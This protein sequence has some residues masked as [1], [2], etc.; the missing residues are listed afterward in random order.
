MGIERLEEA[1]I[2]VASRE[3]AE[4]PGA[5]PEP[6][7]QQAYR[8]RY[9]ATVDAV[10]RAARDEAWDAA[11]LELRQAW[12]AHETKWPRAEDSEQPRRP[13]TPGTWRGDGDRS[14]APEANAEVERGCGRIATLARTSS[15]PPC[16]PSKPKTWI[17]T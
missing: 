6:Q 8:A 12:Q 10:N 15:R 7:D 9:R 5:A 17:A 11:V 16:A 14:L 3:Q 13:A 4:A 1:D 2:P